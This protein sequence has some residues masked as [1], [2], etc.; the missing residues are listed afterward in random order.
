VKKIPIIALGTILAL[1]VVASAQTD[2]EMKNNDSENSITQSEDKAAPTM[3]Q[4][5][6]NETEQQPTAPAD[7][8]VAE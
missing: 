4:P 6:T 5:T 1:G 2:N 8:T 3:D 7:N